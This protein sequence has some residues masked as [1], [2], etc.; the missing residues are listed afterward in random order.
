[1]L[2]YSDVV[3]SRLLICFYFGPPLKLYK[4]LHPVIDG[5]S[6]LL[7]SFNRSLLKSGQLLLQ[8]D[9]HSTDVLCILRCIHK[10]EVALGAE[11]GYWL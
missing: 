11:R 7:L 4:L 10:S 9:V 8:M 3:V 5:D 6:L 2:E 1:M